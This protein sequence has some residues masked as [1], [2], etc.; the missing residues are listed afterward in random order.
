[1]TELCIH[2]KKETGWS[3]GLLY[4]L[5]DNVREYAIFVADLDGVVVSWNIGAERLFGYT[6]GEMIG[7]KAD[8]LFTP[9]DRANN[10]PE[11]EMFAAAADGVAEDERWHLRKDGSRLFVSG[12]QTALYD[13]E[14]QHTGYAKIGRDLTERIEAQR[15]DLKAFETVDERVRERTNDLHESF[16]ALRLEVGERK[17]A[18]QLKAALL[19][20]I[21]RTQENERK[22]IAR[23]IH[24]HI[25]QQLTAL[26][27]RL[28]SLLTKYGNDRAITDDLEE[29]RSITNQV[30]S[31]VDFLAWELRPPAL[32]DLGLVPALKKYVTN[33][34]S[35]FNIPAEF[36]GVGL[37]GKHFVPDC[38][39]N[40]YRIAQEALNNVAKHA[41]A[42]RVSVLLELRDATLGLVVEDDGRGFE[43]DGGD[44]M[45][46]DGR[47]MGLLGMKERAELLGGSAE[48]ETAVGKGTSVYV[49]VPALFDEE[50]NLHVT[51]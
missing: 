25:G 21:V 35:Q 34:S 1:M 10:I 16:E 42:N 41:A 40:V 4:Q 31:E 30:D 44:L 26:Q 6:A 17:Q 14:G 50:K 36:A 8:I 51:T 32:D 29:L 39:I 28:Q 46:G 49:R 5:V 47:G 20:R 15:D 37:N 22:R 11:K 13:E 24:D 18:E 45:T 3:K 12:L 27:F 9:E 43:P 2:L 33:W 19:H 38:E 7:R 23:D 48:I